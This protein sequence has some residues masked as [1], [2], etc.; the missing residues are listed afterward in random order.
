MRN[1]ILIVAAFTLLGINNLNAQV[2]EVSFN[3]FVQEVESRNPS[4]IALK[5]Q[6]EANIVGNRVGLAPD[7]PEV[8]FEPM[9]N[10][11][12]E[13]TAVQSFAFPTMYFKMSKLAKLSTKRSEMEYYSNI[14][15][16]LLNIRSVAIDAIYYNK[17]LIL[18]EEVY[19]NA[20]KVEKFMLKRFEN[21]D[22]N[23]IDKNKVIAMLMEAVAQ[24][25]TALSEYQSLQ[26]QIA[27]LNMSEELK[28]IDTSYPLFK[29]GEK[30]SYV[31]R[32]LQESYA[33]KIANMDSLIA[34][35]QI[36]ISRN[37]WLPNLNV[38][39]K[40]VFERNVPNSGSSGIIVGIS[41]PL[42]KNLNKVKHSKLQYEA[43]KAEMVSTKLN[44]KAFLEALVSTYSSSV[45]NMDRYSD[46]LK[47]NNSSSAILKALEL[48]EI[49]VM[50]YF[51]EANSITEIKLNLLEYERTAYNTAAQMQAYLY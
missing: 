20:V 6:Y 42:W 19:Q 10:G 35:Q 22:A 47:D 40:Y 24:K 31:E 15:N 2:K 17:K 5:K 48:G 39:Y 3:Q 16:T 36:K 45:E 12:T 27:A 46:Y 4:L 41:V 50:E 32:A 23:I 38:G 29:I 33:I 1:I 11:E 51:V 43:T 34:Q 18:L 21:G 44:T 7:D 26:K 49:S 30:E 28:I 13:V 9:F 37:S 25:N 8:G 14:Y